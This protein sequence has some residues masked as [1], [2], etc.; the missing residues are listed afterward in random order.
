MLGRRRRRRANTESALCQRLVF[1]WLR[2]VFASL[3]PNQ[4][5]Y[6]SLVIHFLQ[7]VRIAYL[8][9]TH[10]TDGMPPRPILD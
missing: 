9:P 2:L 8:E 5:F 1:S 6:P 3:G 10:V 7:L 4:L